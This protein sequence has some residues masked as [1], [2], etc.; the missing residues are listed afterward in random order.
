MSRT[1]SGKGELGVDELVFA[2]TSVEAATA[3]GRDHGDLEAAAVLSQYYALVAQTV[4]PI[5]GRVV[6]VM[7][8]GVL[9][10]FPLR[11]ANEAVDVLRRL[12]SSATALWCAFDDRCR[13]Q[14]RVGA[15]PLVSGAM[16]PPGAERFDV[17]GA[18]LSDLFKTPPGD[19]VIM[20][21]VAALLG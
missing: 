6:K 21:E 20:P 11:R 10:V 9:V 19:L 2:I 14:V 1:P 7:G 15:G 8:D 3:A 4:E 18:A 17:Y 16:G 13:V 12:Q 5:E